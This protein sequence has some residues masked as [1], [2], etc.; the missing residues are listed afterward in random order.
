VSGRL[1]GY[2]D[3]AIVFTVDAMFK[4]SD[5]LCPAVSAQRLVVSKTHNI[6]L[7][8]TRHSTSGAIFI[9]LALLFHGSLPPYLG[10]SFCWPSG[11]AILLRLGVDPP[12]LIKASG[13]ANLV[14][15]RPHSP[16]DRPCGGNARFD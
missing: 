16:A 7:A 2:T 10:D 15:V 3:I 1:R 13:R 12:D 9:M 4:L 5:D 11:F 14:L 8:P 6:D